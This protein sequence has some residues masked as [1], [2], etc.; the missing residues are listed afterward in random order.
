[1]KCQYCGNN[2]GLEE[3]YC[4]HCGKLNTQAAKHVEDMEN[5]KEDYDRTKTSV[6]TKSTKFNNRT[7]RL[8]VIAVLLLLVAIMLIITKNYSDFD[9]RMENRE[10]R[11]AQELEKNRENVSATLKEMEEHREYLA[12]HYYVLNN[13]IRTDDEYGDYARVFSAVTSYSVI[14]DDILNILDG[15]DYYGEKTPE[16]WCDDIAIYVADWHL[17]VEGEFWHDSPDSAMHAGEHGAFLAD[18][19]QET[20]DM[21]K[22]YFN[23]TDEQANSMWD[24]EE[25]EIASMLREQYKLLY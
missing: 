17:Y 15:F 9:T 13:Q 3:K 25:S 8:V 1:M 24:M 4:P 5:Y 14:H 7:G 16:D 6:I 18:A 19:K 20:Q 21:I 23:L 22:V 2:I 12:M 11:L 10:K